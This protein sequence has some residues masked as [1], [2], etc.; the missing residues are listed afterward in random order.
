MKP[1]GKC[2]VVAVLLCSFAPAGSSNAA[3]WRLLATNEN[4]V[5]VYYDAESITQAGQDR[6]CVNLKAVFSGSASPVAG[7]GD[8]SHSFSLIEMDCA[9]RQY[10]IRQTTLFD[11]EG[12]S[13]SVYSPRWGDL[14]P[15]PQ[16][17]RLFE[18]A[19]GERLPGGGDVRNRG[20]SSGP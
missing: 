19:C 11:N 20:S 12:R 7:L 4:G 1:M 5:P 6:V 18:V 2:L 16:M 10:L 14:P 8:Y 9:G 3:E 17:E 15:E 13:L